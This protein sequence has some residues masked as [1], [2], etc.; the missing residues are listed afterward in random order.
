MSKGLPTTMGAVPIWVACT[1]TWGHGDIHEPRLLPKTMSES[2]VLPRLGSV[3][4][5]VALL[6]PRDMEMLR[7]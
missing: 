1:A 5:S 4:I 3:L 7:I 6:P 2:V